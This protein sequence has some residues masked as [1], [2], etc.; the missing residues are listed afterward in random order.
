MSVIVPVILSGGSGTRLWPLSRKTFP[1]QFQPLNVQNNGSGQ[2]SM[3][4]ETAL[5]FKGRAGVAA[6]PVV[7]CNEDHRFVV[8]EQFREIGLKPRIILEPEGRNTAPAAAIAALE[9]LKTYGEEALILLLPADHIIADVPAFHQAVD[10][11]RVC[12]EG[13]RLATFGITPN[14]PETGYGYIKQG[15]ALPGMP[16]CFTLEKFIEKPG[17]EKAETLLKEG[18][19]YWNAGIFLFEANG[20]LEELKTHA[21]DLLEASRKS[22]EQGVEDLDF[23][24]LNKEVFLSLRSDSIDYAVMEKTARAVVVPV[25]MGWSDVGSW[26]AL[27]EVSA[28]DAQGNVCVGDVV[29]EGVENSYFRT[30]GKQMIAAVGVKDVV[31]VATRDAILVTHR[32]KTQDVKKIAERLQA[33]N[34]SEAVLHSMVRRPWGAYESIDDGERYQVKRLTVKPGQKLSLQKHFHRAE[35]WVVVSGTAIVHRDGEEHLIAENE[36]IYLPLGCV[37]RLY[38]PGKI[39]LHLIEVQSGSYL[40]EDDI[41]RMEDTYGRA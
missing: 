11:A 22:W 21:P 7:I 14:A 27:W 39:D 20:Y 16:G 29:L 34:R 24:R 12:V 13:G 1:K 9:A 17:R 10:A 40:G 32:D 2:L 35:H 36:S 30:H 25:S 6:E 33:E 8:A 41:V 15:A 31:V 3:I 28:H 5:R 19:Y 18:G 37:H 38:N 4:Q 26:G 23:I